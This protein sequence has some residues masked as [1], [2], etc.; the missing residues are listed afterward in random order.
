MMIEQKHV[1]YLTVDKSA[2]GRAQAD[3]AEVKFSAVGALTTQS[4]ALKASSVAAALVKGDASL[5]WC[6]AQLVGSA[7][8]VTLTNSGGQL[9]LAGNSIDVHTGGAAVMAARSITVQRGLVGM[10]IAQNA[11][12]GDDTKVLLKPSG[13]A[14]LGAGFGAGAIVGLLLAARGLRRRRKD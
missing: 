13:A 10:V 5:A 12:L 7:N 8:D 3:T 6:N 1:D 14:A 4:A 2:L 11:T 9:M